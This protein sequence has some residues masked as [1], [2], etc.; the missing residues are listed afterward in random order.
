MRLGYAA[1]SHG[2]GAVISQGMDDGQ[3]RP[4]AYASRTLNS[5]ESN[6]AQIKREAL[7]IISELKKFH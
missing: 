3:E 7:A 4:V 2:F 1:C 6:Y 5:S